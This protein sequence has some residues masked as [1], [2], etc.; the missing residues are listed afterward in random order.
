M[1]NNKPDSQPVKQP[2]IEPMLTMADI[3]AITKTSERTI[4]QWRAQGYLPSPDLVHGRTV[5]WQNATIVN[6]LRDQAADAV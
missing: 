4:R 2:V 3:A 1:P 5:R 6:W